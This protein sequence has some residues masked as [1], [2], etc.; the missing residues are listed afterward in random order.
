MIARPATQSAAHAGLVAPRGT[1]V[2]VIQRLNHELSSIMSS[3]EMRGAM[4]RLGFRTLSSTAEEFGSLIRQEHARW[5]PVIRDAGL[6][7]E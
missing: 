2:G 7:L 1:P 5:A 6:K 3:T 4:S